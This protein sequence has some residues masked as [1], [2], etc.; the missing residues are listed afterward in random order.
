MNP[1]YA[2]SCAVLAHIL[3]EASALN[4]AADVCAERA[5]GL[6]LHGWLVSRGLDPHLLAGW[7]DV[8]MPS[9][10]V[11]FTLTQSSHT[12]GSMGCQT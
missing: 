2:A 7:D 9:Q 8:K 6:L 1:G 4:L 10:G 3:M 12:L 5:A 11:I